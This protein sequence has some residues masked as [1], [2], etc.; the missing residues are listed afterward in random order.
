ML[1]E[2]YKLNNKIDPSVKMYRVPEDFNYFVYKIYKNMWYLLN[3]R[4][5]LDIEEIQNILQDFTLYMLAENRKNIPRYRVYNSQKHPNIPYHRWF[6]G[7]LNY[8][9]LD[10]WKIKQKERNIFEIRSDLFEE[11]NLNPSN[12]KGIQVYFGDAADSIHFISEIE[13]FLK[14]ISDSKYYDLFL[15][16][17]GGFT[18]KEIADKFQVN[19][20]TVYIW[21]SELKNIISEFLGF[22]DQNQMM[23][24]IRN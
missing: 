18:K 19:E 2:G 21:G 14:G 6:L 1:I 16:K 7:I 20:K 10:Y 17:M 3:H 5:G 13:S 9:I 15:Y 4:V 23:D 24:L 22:K 12:P 11:E 8:F